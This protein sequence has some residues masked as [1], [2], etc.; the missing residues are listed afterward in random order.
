MGMRVIGTFGVTLTMKNISASRMRS[1]KWGIYIVSRRALLFA[2]KTAKTK[3]T[4]AAAFVK[5]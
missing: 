2:D 5:R 1:S 3:H 4:M